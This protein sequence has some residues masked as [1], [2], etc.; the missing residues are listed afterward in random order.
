VSQGLQKKKM[1]S[2]LQERAEAAVE[3]FGNARQPIIIEFAGVPKSGKS[4]TIGALQSFLKRCG[5]KV[6]VV[7]ERASVC[8]I[9]DKKHFNFNVWTSCTTLVQILEKTQTPP[10]PED[11][12]ILIL[13]RGIFDAVC[14]LNF[15][16]GVGRLNPTDRDIIKRFLLLGDWK[17][18]ISGVIAMTVSPKDA[19]TREQGLLPVE[20][21]KGSIMNE[22]ILQ[23]MADALDATVSEI[24]SDF[25]VFRVNSSD[26]K[27]NAPA[28]AEVVADFVL[29][30]IESHL[31]EEI[32]SIPANSLR[33]VFG[34]KG[35]LDAQST[36]P[37]MRAIQEEGVF[38][39]RE[40][41]EKD[42]TR[43]QII[44]VAVVRNRSGDILAIFCNYA[45]R[46]ELQKTSSIRKS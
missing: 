36:Q 4:S 29:G 17:R 14:W 13:D 16:V 27:F 18:R 19:M 30:V 10:R 44:P 25:T 33:K 8:P 43:V 32:L 21:G 46:K 1:K 26:R 20:G 9:R 39:A 40:I 15:M 2:H 41:V 34:G 42:D 6:E 3:R 31:D 5:F 28:T 11:V 22:T 24:A 7:I 23:K 38:Q 37:L 35:A 45:G 12:Q